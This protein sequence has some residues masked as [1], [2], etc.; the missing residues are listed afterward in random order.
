ME[1]LWNYG[2][3]R[4][5]W[6]KMISFHEQM[7]WSN[8]V[9]AIYHQDSVSMVTKISPGDHS[10][11]KRSYYN[12]LSKDYCNEEKNYWQNTSISNF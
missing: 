1:Y 8:H 6:L 3:G 12:E 11:M 10:L 5:A 7:A 4:Y 9:G 2:G